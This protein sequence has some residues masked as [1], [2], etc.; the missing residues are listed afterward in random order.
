MGQLKWNCLFFTIDRDSF[1]DCLREN[2]VVPDKTKG[3]D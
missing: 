2:D 1:E 3:I